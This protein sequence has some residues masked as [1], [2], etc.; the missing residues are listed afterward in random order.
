MNNN[1]NHQ[2][3]DFSETLVSY[4]YGE[5]SAAESDKFKAHLAQCGECAAEFAGFGVVRSSIA[6][7]RQEEFAPMAVP[8]IEMPARKVIITDE[9]PSWL[10]GIRAFFT[11][12]MTLAAAG[13]A[14]L[15]V[16]AALTLA[17]IS[18]QSSGNENMLAQNSAPE[19]KQQVSNAGS[20]TA[21]PGE[22][23]PK[24]TSVAKQGADEK[25]IDPAAAKHGSGRE[26]VNTAAVKVANTVNQPKPK[27][28]PRQVKQQ[29]PATLDIYDDTED[30]SLRLADLFAE[31]DTN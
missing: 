27:N 8:V 2:P 15:V 16:C 29:K 13:F 18:S 31:A 6:E 22:D 30:D 1:H 26:Y 21:A 12:K 24:N 17:V 20:E 14:A 4:I 23:S 5:T 28:A 7:W 11:P 3:C 25:D 19:N 10:D 9:S